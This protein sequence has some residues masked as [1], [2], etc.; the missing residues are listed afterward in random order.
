MMVF[1]I[2]LKFGYYDICDFIL[3]NNDFK[4]YV[5]EK[6]LDGKNVCYYVVEFGFVRLF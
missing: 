5:C 6:F 2:G 3:K 4:K 1:Y